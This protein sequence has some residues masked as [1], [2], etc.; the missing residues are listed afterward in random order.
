MKMPAD[1]YTPLARPY[2]GPGELAYPF[3]YWTAM[4]THCGRI[5]DK[6][7]RINLSQVFA[8]QNVG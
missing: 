3:H 7:R 1:V 4:V 2:E 5:C 8:G 6:G